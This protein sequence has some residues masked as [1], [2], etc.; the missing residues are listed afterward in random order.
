[1][2]EQLELIK[3]QFDEDQ[4][5]VNLEYAKMGALVSQSELYARKAKLAKDQYDLEKKTLDAMIKK[6]KTEKDL[7][8]SAKI[9]KKI[10]K[11]RITL[12]NAEAK[13]IKAAMLR[14]RD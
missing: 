1:M 14:Q 2:A 7:E 6:A 11:Q 9:Q 3:Q 10:V 4:A 13:M 5:L 8:E 12:R